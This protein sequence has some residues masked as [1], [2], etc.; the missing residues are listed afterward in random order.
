MEAE[1]KQ[2]ALGY[3]LLFMAALCWA[4]NGVL[5]LAVKDAGVGPIEVAFW[6]A[7]IGGGL[8]VIHALVT[9]N[10]KVKNK[11]RLIFMAFGIPAVT[12]LF[13]SFQI[14]V[15][16]IGMSMTTM[17]QYT[18]IAWIMLWGVVFFKESISKW[19]II[20]A[21][22]A[23]GG[24][25]VICLSGGTITQGITFY[26]LVAALLSGFLYSLISPF[27]KKFMQ[28]YSPMAIYMY[29]MPF[30]ALCMLPFVEFAEKDTTTWIWIVV[31]AIVSVWA[32]YLCY[33]EGV[34]RIEVSKV[35]VITSVEPVIAAFIGL[36]FFNE[37]FTS[38]GWIGAGIIILGVFLTVKR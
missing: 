3:L 14:G 9:N 32:A 16:E 18:C 1:T 21:S 22:L 30:G 23:L 11:D 26:G 33:C 35:G 19:K 15:R 8:F 31:L 13:V 6:R 38:M 17:L 36:T 24:A 10:Y 34:K 7:L 27:S 29:T 4:M 28:T 37:V 25:M 20:S 12:I 2:S 5:G